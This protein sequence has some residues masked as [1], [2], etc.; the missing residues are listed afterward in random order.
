M[1]PCNKIGGKGLSSAIVLAK[2]N[3][4]D[5]SASWVHASSCH[6]WCLLEWCLPAL[7]KLA[8][9][10]LSWD[11]LLPGIMA[12]STRLGQLS[13]CPSWMHCVSHAVTSSY[14][15]CAWVATCAQ[16]SRKFCV[17]CCTFM[18]LG[19]SHICLSG[20]KVYLDCSQSLC[21]L[22]WLKQNALITTH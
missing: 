19:C 5:L 9:S 13:L 3:L 20:D 2:L 8:C 22:C 18:W 15:I 11:M 4:V 7:I 21:I 6:L 16:G 12:F 10:I 17:S 1:Y 14:S